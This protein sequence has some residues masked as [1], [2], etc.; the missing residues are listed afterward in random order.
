MALLLGGAL[1]AA[2]TVGMGLHELSALQ[3]LSEVERAAEQRRD[4]IHEAVI[5][6]LRSATA[7]SLVGL[8]FSMEEKRKALGLTAAQ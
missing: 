7:F 8:D 5:V 3:K 2:A 4:A 6:I 1:V